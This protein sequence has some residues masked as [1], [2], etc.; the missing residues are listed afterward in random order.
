METNSSGLTAQMELL[1]VDTWE[2]ADSG[3]MDV[4]TP[5]E[6]SER[7]PTKKKSKNH[8]LG[9]R[10]REMSEENNERRPTKKKTKTKHA[11]KSSK[12]ITRKSL[13]LSL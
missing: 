8:N 10:I 3:K 6:N 11:K 7:R 4:E 9:K 1:Q 5:E 2:T 12:N 13:S